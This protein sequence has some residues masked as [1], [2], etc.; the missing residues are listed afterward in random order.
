MK[1]LPMSKG[2]LRVADEEIQFSPTAPTSDKYSLVTAEALSRRQIHIIEPVQEET[3]EQIKNLYDQL[4]DDDPVAPIHVVV[5]TAGGDVRSMLGIMNLLLLSKT[6][7]YTYILGE[8]CSAGAWIYLCGHKRY[9]PKTKLISFMLHPIA[10]GK[11][12]DTLGNHAIHNKYVS[13]LSDN[14]VALTAERTKIPHKRIR[15][16]STIETQYFVGD[17]LFTNGIATDILETSSFWVTD[18]PAESKKKPRK[19]QQLLLVE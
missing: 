6:P 9:A 7:C 2:S 16:L 4:V 3:F 17:E 18:K 10:W 11:E 14:L 19:K 8:V 15:R 12:D 5:G 13:M 1:T